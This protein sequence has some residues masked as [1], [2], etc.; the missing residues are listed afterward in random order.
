MRVMTLLLTAA[1]LIGCTAPETDK[2]SDELPKLETPLELPRSVHW[3]RNSAEYQ[4]LM[5]QTYSLAANQLRAVTQDR[6]AGTWAVALDADETVISNSLYEKELRAAG[7][8]TNDTNWAAWVDRQEATPLPGAVEFIGLAKELGGYVAIVT[9]RGEAD[10]PATRENFEKFDIP[11]D[12]MLCK[13]DDGEKEGRW[14]K[15]ESGMASE[16]VPPVE[17]VM[18]LGDNIKD[19]PDH[20]QGLRFDNGGL[21]SDYGSRYF[22]MPNTM[23]GSWQE[24]AHD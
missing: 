21:F 5:R 6:E 11:F 4:A 3:M 15:V 16:E 24:N 10:C 17:I 18:W 2:V 1:V 14:E 9:N 20:D 22:I 13:G 7:H 12:V 19:F 8:Q 23:Y